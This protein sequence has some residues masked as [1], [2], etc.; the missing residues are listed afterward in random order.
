MKNILFLLAL[1]AIVFASCHVGHQHKEQDEH[2]EAEEHEE[3]KFQYTAYSNDFELFAEA[4][5]FIVGE[6][7]NVLSHLS[8]IPA[9]SALETGSITIR[10]IVGGKEVSQT[11]DKPTR[12]GIYSFDL[13]AETE[14]KGLLRYEITNDN[15]V[16]E[17]VVPD[18][19][20]FSSHEQ[21]HEAAAQQEAVSKTN[22]TVFT[23]EQSWKVEFATSLPQREPFGQVIRTTA[24]VQSSQGEEMIVGSRMNG[25]VMIPG[26]AVLEGKEVSKG[27]VLFSISGSAMADNNISVRYAEA[28]NNLEKASADY[29]RAKKLAVDRII[30]EKDLLDT[31]NRFDNAKAL[32]DNLNSNFNASGQQVKSPMT[33]FVKQVFVSNGSYVEAG[34][35]V[36]IVSQN[37]TLTLHAEVQQKYASLLSSV[38]SANIHTV[39]DNQTYS[40]EELNGKVLSF[41]KAANTDNYLIPVALQ[42]DN[43]GSFINGGFVEVY[44]KALT[45]SQALTVPNTSLLEDQGA[46][47]VYVQVTPE[48]FEKREVKTGGTDGLKTEITQGIAPEERIV[49]KGAIL[50]KLAQATGTLDAHSGHVH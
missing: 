11:L 8:K 9:F 39:H 4:D 46:Y 5:P 49:T 47:F 44:L 12:K 32:F 48:L 42:I 25:T 30:S 10:L 35:P 37:K 50:I 26:N 41:G 2:E 23:K 7:A 17:V 13:K 28:K 1:L 40:L 15:K 24:Q 20:V 27:Q 18:I 34:H 22:T 31:K 36:V 43:T 16:Y 38:T 19:I 45:N 6:T 29:E 3:V 14:G 21:A 33:G